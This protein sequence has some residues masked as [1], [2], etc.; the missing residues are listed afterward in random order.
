MVLNLSWEQHI[1]SMAANVAFWL[2]CNKCGIQ[3][4][5]LLKQFLFCNFGKLILFGITLQVT[6]PELFYEDTLQDNPPFSQ[7]G[8]WDS[9]TGV[10]IGG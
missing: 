9:T 8:R 3:V 5:N 7:Y 2:H 6:N 4:H 1:L 10:V